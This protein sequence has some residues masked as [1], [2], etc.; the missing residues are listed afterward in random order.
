MAKFKELL[1]VL[2]K[3]QKEFEED[4]K[5]KKFL[6]KYMGLFFFLNDLPKSKYKNMLAN[7]KSE[8]E[9]VKRYYKDNKDNRYLKHPFF[10]LKIFYKEFNPYDTET[11]EDQINTLNTN[12]NEVF[13]TY[14]AIVHNPNPELKI[15][16]EDS[17]PVKTIKNVI[18]KFY[19]EKE[20]EFRKIGNN[21]IFTL[22]EIKEI[23]L[24]HVYLHHFFKD[25]TCYKSKKNVISKEEYQNIKNRSLK[26]FL[27][28][29]KGYVYNKYAHYPILTLADDLYS[30]LKIIV[31]DELPE[32][33]NELIK[34]K[35]L[36]IE[37]TIKNNFPQGGEQKVKDLID[38]LYAFADKNNVKAL[39]QKKGYNDEEING[40]INLI[41]TYLPKNL[42]VKTVTKK[43]MEPWEALYIRLCEAK[44][45][46]SQYINLDEEIDGIKITNDV[47]DFIN[48]Y[49]GIQKLKLNG[50][51]GFYKN[52]KDEVLKNLAIDIYNNFQSSNNSS[53]D[54]SVLDDLYNKLAEKGDN[55]DDVIEALN[56]LPNE[57][58]KIESIIK[59]VQEYKPE[60]EEFTDE[61]DNMYGA[62]K[63]RIDDIKNNYNGIN[64]E[65]LINTIKEGVENAIE[66]IDERIGKVKELTDYINDTAEEIK[67]N[68]KNDENI[69][70]IAKDYVNKINEK[71]REINDKFKNNLKQE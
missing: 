55:L 63:T 67:N 41:K 38:A 56:K 35:T 21:K 61:F 33:K 2:T 17:V 42:K 37:D 12:M 50:K 16:K 26:K 39:L 34:V 59:S 1:E 40:I 52:T 54:F 8:K 30:R 66:K 5:T 6:D 9:I 15:K 32:D 53:N 29:T 46:G 11:L 70:D 48:K 62:L 57:I 23:T 51:I 24:E 43:G 4:I 19:K 27:T 45:T 68:I 13:Q 65:E 58:E 71:I 3:T 7:K 31:N 28:E 47:I 60:F 25:V 10:Y 22:E 20:E 69:I 64:K 18:K 36:G 44:G 14:I 49:T